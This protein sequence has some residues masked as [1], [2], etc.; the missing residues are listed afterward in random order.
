MTHLM[1]RF[2][3]P[4]RQQ[5]DFGPTEWSDVSWDM[6]SFGE[7]GMACSLRD[8]S[9]G[10]MLEANIP[11]PDTSVGKIQYKAMLG[12]TNG[13]FPFIYPTVDEGGNYYEL[14]IPYR[15]SFGDAVFS[16]LMF[17]VIATFV[18]GGLGFSLNEMFSENGYLARSEEGQ[19]G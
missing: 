7:T 18:W 5:D 14:S 19:D 12:T 13:A 8:G 15:A 2:V 11:L 17:L 1:W 4:T 3:E 6:A 9:N 16:I 10:T